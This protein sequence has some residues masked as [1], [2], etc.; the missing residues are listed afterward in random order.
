[1]MTARKINRARRLFLSLLDDRGYAKKKYLWKFG[2]EPDL[3]TPRYFSE[4]M[5]WLKLRD[6]NCG[7]AI[8]ADKY[9]VRGN[10]AERIGKEYLNELYFVTDNPGNIDYEILPDSFVLKATH[11][12]GFNIVCRGKKDFDPK[13]AKKKM[14]GWLSTNYAQRSR[15]RQYEAIPRRIICER[16]P[17]D[18]S[19]SLRDCKVLCFG[20]EP[21]LV[22]VDVDRHGGHMRSFFQQTGPLSR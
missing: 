14:Y 4:K 12:S 6:D 20:S 10:G 17:E 16:Y 2:R 1:M 11:G 22:W 5:Q 18:E 15:E 21:R 8:F 7:H 19:G 3:E 13:L 9:G